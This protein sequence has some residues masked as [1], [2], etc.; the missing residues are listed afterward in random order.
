[1]DLTSLAVVEFQ[2][3]AGNMYTTLPKVPHKH[4]VILLFINL[5]IS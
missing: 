5:T 4:S 2:T 1:M 3:I